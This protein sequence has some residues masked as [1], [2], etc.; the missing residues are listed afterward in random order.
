MQVKQRKRV[1]DT[2]D[3]ALAIGPVSGDW[4][5]NAERQMRAIE[6]AVRRELDEAAAAMEAAEPVGDA[7]IR[8]RRRFSPTSSAAV[9]EELLYASTRGTRNHRQVAD[10]LNSHAAR[11]E[12]QL[13]PTTAPEAGQDGGS[14]VREQPENGQSPDTDDMSRMSAM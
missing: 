8:H 3:S 9:E 1:A 4:I 10:R 14:S 11:L 7:T 2:L 12:A 13:R 6:A 5:A